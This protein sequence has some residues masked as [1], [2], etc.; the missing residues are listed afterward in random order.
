MIYIIR[1]VNINANIPQAHALTHYS[2]YLETHIRMKYYISSK[3]ILMLQM[4]LIDPSRFQSTSTMFFVSYLNCFLIPYSKY[5][6]I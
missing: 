4:T 3:K 5:E 2:L 1:V 6:R